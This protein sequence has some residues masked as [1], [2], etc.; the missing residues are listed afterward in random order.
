MRET[1]KWGEASCGRLTAEG[2]RLRATRKALVCKAG[3]LV[4]LVRGGAAWVTGCAVFPAPFTVGLPFP[5]VCPWPP[6]RELTDPARAGWVLGSPSRPSGLCACFEPVP[7]CFG[8]CSFTMWCEVREGGAFGPFSFLRVA[9][10]IWGPLWFH[11]H[12]R[13]V[14]SIS[15]TNTIGISGAPAFTALGRTDILATVIL[16]FHEHGVSFHRF[17]SSSVSSSM[18]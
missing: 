10:A 8:G 5:S 6:C 12:L 14:C 4:R 2:A 13:R 17:V 9:L 7:Q 3:F 18:S 15:V 1:E 16:A 11:T